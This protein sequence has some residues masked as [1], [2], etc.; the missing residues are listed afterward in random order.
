M[1]CGLNNFHLRCL[2][3][4]I[5]KIREHGEKTNDWKSFD[6]QFQN[7]YSGVLTPSSFKK[8]ADRNLLFSLAYYIDKHLASAVAKGLPAVEGSPASAPL[9]RTSAK[10][11][12]YGRPLARHGFQKD[13]NDSAFR[14]VLAA[15]N[16]VLGVDSSGSDANQGII[17]VSTAKPDRALSP[18]QQARWHKAQAEERGRLAGF[19]PKLTKWLESKG[20]VA[21]P[22]TGHGLNCLIHALLQHASGDYDNPEPAEAAN[23]RA[24]IGK[25]GMLHSDDIDMQ[26]LVASINSDFDVSMNVHVIQA[27]E[28]GLP[29]ILPKLEMGAEDNVVIWQQ[30]AHYVAVVARKPDDRNPVN[31]SASYAPPVSADQQAA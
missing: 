7:R 24:E 9:S 25:G 13:R 29:V 28:S 22:N 3:A 1:R 27:T 19:N 23:Y 14:I 26:I 16:Q 30:G 2:L 4:D 15:S 31:A 17:E 21:V 5:T 20:L 8:E 11:G 18:E 12:S 10:S 6:K